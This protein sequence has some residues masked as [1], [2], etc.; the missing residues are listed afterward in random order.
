M[1]ARAHATWKNDGHFNRLK[2][3]LQALLIEAGQQVKET[4]RIVRWGRVEAER[5][6]VVRAVEGCL[7][8]DSCCLQR[9]MFV[10]MRIL[11]RKRSSL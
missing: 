6:A 4:T 3:T 9:S 1:T 10:N 2:E 11:W 5:K 7:F 8:V